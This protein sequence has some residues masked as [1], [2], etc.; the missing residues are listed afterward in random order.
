MLK[1]Q[2]QALIKKGLKGIEK[3]SL[4]LSNVG[5]IAQTPHPYSLGSALT[6]P[7]ITTDYSEA[8]L[9]F[10]TPPLANIDSTLSFMYKIHQFVYSQLNDEYLLA[11]SMPCGIKGDESIPIAQYGKSNI[12]QMKHIYRQGLAHRYGRTMQAIAGIHFNYSV[13][14]KLWPVLHKL[15]GSKLSLENFKSSAYFDLIRNFQ[16]QGWIILYLFGASPAIC[17]NFFASRPE[18]MSQFSECDNG[19]LYHPHAT[20][21]RMSNIGYKSNNQANLEIDYNSLDGYVDSLSSA[22]NTPSPEYENFGV[23]VNGQYQQLNNNILQIEN[24]F[25]STVRPKQIITPCE[26][27]TLALKRRGVHYVEMR[28]L[29]LNPFNPIGIDATQARFIEAF[30]LACLLQDSPKSN[31]AESEINN[32]NQLNVANNGRQP[33]L[34]LIKNNQPILLKDWANNILDNMQTVCTI[35]D[36]DEPDN[37]YTQ[38]LNKQRELVE[39]ANLTPSAKLL[40][41]MCKT[42]VPFARFADNIS[43][44]HA[45]TFNSQPLSKVESD[46]FTHLAKQSHH[47]QIEIETKDSLS[48]DDFL[49]HYFSQV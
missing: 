6:H 15:E 48:L 7:H 8:L 41:A 36:A 9:E 47:K 16:R 34:E 24:E 31:H 22:I 32:H 3:E 37:L 25:Y 14:E 49:T 18:L 38:A 12:G 4:R 1:N 26:K 2:R 21:L 45:E 44:K 17:K 46:F 10:I 30:L 19:T 35:L 43:Q 23:K 39:N 13:P 33:N 42:E 27:P 40:S 5:F 28:S 29:D 20:S 11:S